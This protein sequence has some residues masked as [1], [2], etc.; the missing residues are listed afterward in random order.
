MKML[1]IMTQTELISNGRSLMHY[2]KQTLNYRCHYIQITR[3]ERMW[4]HR[5]SLLFPPGV[6]WW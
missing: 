4:R 2:E 1:S 5:T 3:I 6:A